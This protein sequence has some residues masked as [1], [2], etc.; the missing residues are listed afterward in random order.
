MKIMYFMLLLQFQ[1]LTLIPHAAQFTVNVIN[2]LI[3]LP[4]LFELL[5]LTID[6]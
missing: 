2:S 6:S 5:S 3:T 4:A 1:I